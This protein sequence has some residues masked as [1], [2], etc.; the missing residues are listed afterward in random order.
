LLFVRPAIP[1]DDLV[2]DVY[3]L[4]SSAY[5]KPFPPQKIVLGCEVREKALFKLV[6]QDQVLQAG[7]FLPGSH[8][9]EIPARE[10][11]R[12]TG[13]RKYR[14]ELK[15]GPLLQSREIVLEVRL[16][17]RYLLRKSEKKEPRRYSLSLYLGERML[18]SSSRFSPQALDLK[19]NLPPWP[20]VYNPF[21]LIAEDRAYSSSVS[22]PDV[23]TGIRDV[24]REM[25]FGKGK[26][27][28][29]ASRRISRIKL[30]F[31]RR[32]ERGEEWWWEAWIELKGNGVG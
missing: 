28:G 3:L 25:G 27:E 24:L 11:L 31:P 20:D 29:I 22:V 26:T 7:E 5:G 1:A 6:F 30:S 19:F 18:Y 21:G 17:P 32:S 16:I 2:T 8:V 15:K 9:L 12:S 13:T 14:L 23:V 10:L 4:D